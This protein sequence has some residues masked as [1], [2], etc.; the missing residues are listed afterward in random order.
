[1]PV[2]GVD[3]VGK[4]VGRA[5]SRRRGE[6]ADRLVSPAPI[7]RVLG[8][9]HQLDVREVRVVEV[10]DKLVGQVAIIEK[11]TVLAA[12]F[13][14]AQ[15]NFV[16][17]D[18]LVERLALAARGEPFVVIP[19]KLIHVPNDRGRPGPKLRCKAVGV[20]FGAR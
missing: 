3:E 14:R 9:R 8:D 10:H 11:R 19:G 7:E 13:P 15:V 20:G 6:V 16:D 4:V 12:S 17:C 2:H 1:M 5:E 18:R